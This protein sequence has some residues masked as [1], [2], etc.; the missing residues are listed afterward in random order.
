VVGNLRGELRK[1][2]DRVL[3]KRAKAAQKAATK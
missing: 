1:S 3:K 2:I